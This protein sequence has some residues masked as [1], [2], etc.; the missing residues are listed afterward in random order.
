LESEALL[1]IAKAL[2]EAPGSKLTVLSCSM[3]QELGSSFGK[4]VEQEFA[5]TM[6]RNLVIKKLTVPFED[7][8]WKTIVDR[9]LKRNNDSDRRRL[10]RKVSGR[11][12]D[13]DVGVQERVVSMLNLLIAPAKV[14]ARKITEGNEEE[15]LGLVK[16]FAAAKKRLPTKE[17]LQAFAKN[18]GQ[19]LKYSEVAPLSKAF[20]GKLLDAIVGCEVTAVDTTQ[21]KTTGTLQAWEE[22]NDHWRLNIETQDGTRFRFTAVR[23]PPIEV[24]AAVADWLKGPADTE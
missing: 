5:I 10:K 24:S 22:K 16:T 14:D 18:N 15:K 23:E 1:A 3:Q 13:S 17:Q 19:P 11:Q 7:V 12:Q 9:C 20:R 2:R 4:V 21:K 6:E 8:H